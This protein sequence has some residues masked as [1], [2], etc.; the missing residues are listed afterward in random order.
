V[1]GAE[2]S[3]DRLEELIAADALGGLERDEALELERELAAHGPDC[4]ECRR[5]LVDY[6][7]VAGRLATALE[8]V[9]LSAAAEDRLM[10]AVAAESGTGPGPVGPGRPSGAD[11][12]AGLRSRALTLHRGGRVAPRGSGSPAR[13]TGLAPGRGRRLVA[14]VAVAAAV[15][16]L[17]G[18]VG[19]AL[20]PRGSPAEARFVAFV[21]QP[22][23]RIA[24][25]PNRDG[26]RLA[27]AFRPGGGAAWVL[28][29]NL[30][31]PP[32]GR[33]YELWYRPGPSGAMRPAGT[34]VP[35]DGRVLAEA[36]VGASFDALA[37]S[38]EPEGGSRQPTTAPVF[39]T[40]VT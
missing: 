32:D 40:T 20:A 12:G 16:V 26:Q 23:V 35:G 13:R 7:E 5:L 14:A 11:R 33:V 19:Y 38:V 25:F 36:R 27:V 39:L 21:S 31:T 30:A 18:A 8:P 37:V 29:T 3:H 17:A 22:G 15:A 28:G 34:F 9:P 10:A 1:S 24:P 6:A 4:E 2:R